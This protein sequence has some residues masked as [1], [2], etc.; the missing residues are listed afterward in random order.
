[1]AGSGVMVTASMLGAVLSMVTVL[2]STVSPSVL[3]SLGVTE[4]KTAW[5]RL[6]KSELSV[7]PVSPRSLPSTDH[8]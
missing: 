7:L 1:M 2:E 8:A 5:S 3:P 6:K 4:Q